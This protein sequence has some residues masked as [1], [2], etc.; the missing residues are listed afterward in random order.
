MQVVERRRLEAILREHALDLT[1]VTERDGSA[2]IG[3][4]LS[5]DLLLLSRLHFLGAVRMCHMRLVECTSGRMLAAAR[6]RL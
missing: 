4:L 5:A 2:D 6:V 3:K 1:G